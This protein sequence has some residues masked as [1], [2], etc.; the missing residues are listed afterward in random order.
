MV[1][2]LHVL[3]VP[4]SD[5]RPAGVGEHLGAEGLEIGQQPVAFD[6][7]ADLLGTGGDE[8]RGPGRQ[9]LGQ[10]VPGDAGRPGYVLV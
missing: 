3:A 9:P 6:G 1:A 2:V 8:Q 4:L 5:A 10:G 7:G